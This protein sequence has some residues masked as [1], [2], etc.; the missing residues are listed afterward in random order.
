MVVDSFALPEYINFDVGNDKFHCHFSGRFYKMLA[1]LSK[2][3]SKAHPD[4]Q[5][6]K[7]KPKCTSKEDYVRNYSINALALCLLARNYED[8][9]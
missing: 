8:A 6:A 7:S 9:R 3:M 2:R 1:T 4:L 5:V